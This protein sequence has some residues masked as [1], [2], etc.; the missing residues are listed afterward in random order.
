MSSG[1]FHTEWY[2]DPPWDKVSLTWLINYVRH[3]RTNPVL[4]RA[5]EAEKTDFEM[6]PMPKEVIQHIASSK[7]SSTS[8]GAISIANI[9]QVADVVRSFSDALE[10]GKIDDAVAL[11]SP[12]Y[13]DA[14]GRDATKLKEVLHNLHAAAPGLKIVPFSTDNILLLGN[15]LLATVQVAWQAKIG[16][17]PTS[18]SAEIELLLE[19]DTKGHWT[20]TSVRAL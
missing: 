1:L 17:A 4:S 8:I 20:I 14:H 11:L 15:R 13:S 6:V 3:I 18:A 7:L 9:D 12:K 10:S 19:K 2:T 5:L 16:R